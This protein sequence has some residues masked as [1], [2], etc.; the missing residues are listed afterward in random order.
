V[1]RRW[2]VIH[3]DRD[4]KGV[5]HAEVD[6][7]DG[8][9][10]SAEGT[11]EREAALVAAR[12]SLTWLVVARE[13]TQG[14]LSEERRHLEKLTEQMTRLQDAIALLEAVPVVAA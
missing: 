9:T 11:T 10:F 6:D 13:R 1:P 4:D 5:W 12:E 7:V 2:R 8:M 14:R 3:T